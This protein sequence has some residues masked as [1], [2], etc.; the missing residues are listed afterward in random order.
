[1]IMQ[2]PLPTPLL[3]PIRVIAALGLIGILNFFRWIIRHRRGLMRLM[4]QDH[5]VPIARE[6][7]NNLILIAGVITVVFSSLLLFLLIAA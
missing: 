5:V 7:R 2:T 1:M 3:W 4:Y 6:P